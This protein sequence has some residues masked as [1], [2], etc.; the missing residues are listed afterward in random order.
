MDKLPQNPSG[1][2]SPEVLNPPEAAQL[3]RCGLSTV[4]A[5]VRRK[6]LPHFRVGRCLKFYRGELLA[7]SLHPRGR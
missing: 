4:Y 1:H 2:N 5:D 3:L 6:R 7:L